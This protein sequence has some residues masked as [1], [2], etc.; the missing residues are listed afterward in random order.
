[1]NRSLH[2][3]KGF[4]LVEILMSL[5]LLSGLGLMAAKIVELI[6]TNSKVSEKK[7]A[8]LSYYLRGV[9]VLDT[10]LRGLKKH[11]FNQNLLY[12]IDPVTGLYARN[13]TG[14]AALTFQQLLME[15]PQNSAP[16]TSFVFQKKFD[17]RF[18]SYT[19]ICIPVSNAM[20]NTG[21]TY[22]SIS[23]NT[24]WPFVRKI[25]NFVKVHCCQR[26]YPNCTTNP[27]L[28]SNS[29][30]TVQVYRNDPSTNVL[31][32]LLRGGDYKA[33]SGLGYFIFSHKTNEKSLFARYFVFYNECMSQR[34]MN[35]VTR[36]KCN[37]AISLKTTEL[38][39]DLD[40]SN[41]GTNNL[42]GEI[43]I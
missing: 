43:G 36:P 32:P 26:R 19:A 9:T 3:Q 39:K 31:T 6:E 10:N 30:Y 23:K 33:V 18:L 38:L 7:E 37:K 17:T 1:M 25:N 28:T 14:T 5:A 2:N 24:L 16:L 11:Q 34:I 13:A 22:A 41:E 35:G 29:T 4:T 27:V 40:L 42:G 15:V 12:R 20:A 8:L 21:I